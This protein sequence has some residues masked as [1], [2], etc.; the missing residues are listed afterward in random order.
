MTS[1]LIGDGL[2]RVGI[3]GASGIAPNAVIRP[4][5]R[6]DDV[7]VAAVGARGHARAAAYA[8]AHG[9]PAAYGSYEELLADPA[10]DLVYVAL[11]PS[12][13]A[14]WTIA[15][16]EAGKHVL[17]EKPFTM[18][19]DEARQVLEVAARTGLRVIEAFHDRYHPLWNRAAEIV[20][21]L[22]PL[23]R[24]EGEF[25]VSNPYEAGAIRH[26]PALGGGSLMDLGCYPLT[27][28]RSITGEE[29]IVS[30]ATAE[31]N[32][33]GTDLSMDARLTFP[34]GV[35]GRI[36]SSMSSPGLADER[37]AIGELGML[38]VTYSVFPTAGHTITWTRDGIE[39]YETV[40]GRET[41]DHQLEVVLDAL[42]TGASV[43]TE[44][45]F[46]VRG[47]QAM[48]AIRVAA[49]EGGLR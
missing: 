31:W 19:A 30:S 43:P 27:W 6:R 21:T 23:Q 34:S 33:S 18:N 4:V 38:R 26:E 47:M 28:V 7:V 17:C 40:S 11:P 37:R 20:A 8:A 9:I 10:I 2:V 48:D 1:T 36:R 13:H 12:A 29:P 22:G 24:V 32:P 44:G 42:R 49:L 35:E 3:L 15:A 41:Y 5:A 45:E 39:H 16:L 46:V 25:L 14:A